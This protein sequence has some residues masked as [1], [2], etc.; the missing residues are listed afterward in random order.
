MDN[1]RAYL[2]PGTQVQLE[3]GSLYTITGAP[4]GSGGGSILYPAE[5]IILHGDTAV[6]DGIVYVLKECYPISPEH[7]F[8]RDAQGQIRPEHPEK[9]EQAYL[10]RVKQM[11]L[12][13]RQ[14]T[15]QIYRTSSRLIPIR[16]AAA[17]VFLTVPGG[18]PV[19][20]ENTV[21][22]MED[23][24]S[25]GQSLDA[26]LHQQCRMTTLQVFR[27]IQQVLFALREIHQAG[28]L[29]LDI[30]GGNIFIK[31]TLEDESDIATIID[32]GSARPLIN[33]QTEPI[34]D[35]VIFTTHGFS[36]PEIL[37]HNDGTLRLGPEADLYSVGCLLLYL[38]TGSRYSVNEL[39]SNTTGKY[40][41]R[42]KLRKLDCPRH[43]VDR[44]QGI[45]AHALA[46][47]PAQRYHTAE[48]ML[49]DVTGLLKAL[50]PYRSDLAAV[51]YD[52]FVCYRHGP[53]DSKAAIALQRHLEQ[54]RA[55][56]GISAA[57]HPFHRVFV[58]EGELSSCADFGAQI[59]AALKNAGWLI[60]IC[61]PDTPGSAWVQLEI[62]TF[63]EYH[64]RSRILAVLTGGEPAESFPP[65]LL[66]NKD[67]Q[68]VLA[69][70]ARGKD[71]GSVLAKLKK[72]ALL[73]IVAPML[74]TTYDTLKQRRR[75]YAFQRTAILAV[76]ALAFTACFAA[77]TVYQNR[78]TNEAYQSM[79]VSQ[80]RYL[81]QV[82]GQ[83]LSEGDRISAIQVALEALPKGE[84]DNSRPLVT[85]ALYALNNAVYAY[86]QPSFNDFIVKGTLDTES[87][88]SI[89]SAGLSPSGNHLLV[90][91]ES[92]RMNLFDLETD[93]QIA[94]ITP[95]DLVAHP[96]D[97]MIYH[98][99]YLADDQMIVFL[100]D[101]VLCWKLSTQT[102][103][104]SVPYE[105]DQTEWDS[106]GSPYDIQVDSEI[107]SSGSIQSILSHN[108][109][110]LFFT[111]ELKSD[112]Y[113]YTLD[114]ASGAVTARVSLDSAF[115]NTDV[116]W[117]FFS[118]PSAI[119][120]SE[121]GRYAVLGFSDMWNGHSSITAPLLVDLQ[122][123]ECFVLENRA[124]TVGSAEILSICF[125]SEQ[126]IA[127][128]S[129]DISYYSYYPE[130]HFYEA[131]CYDIRS[132]QQLWH[133]SGSCYTD[134]LSGSLQ[135]E[136]QILEGEENAE[137]V[138]VLNFGNTIS[139]LS[140]DSGEIRSSVSCAFDVAGYGKYADSRLFVALEDGTLLQLVYGS[141]L[142][143]MSSAQG[144][145]AA[146]VYRPE[147][148]EFLLFEENGTF[149]TIMSNQ[150]GDLN[151]TKMQL[152][153][154]HAY[155]GYHS[156]GERS[157][158]VI[159]SNNLLSVYEPLS[160]NPIAETEAS[161]DYQV[162]VIGIRNTDDGPVLW[163]LLNGFLNGFSITD[164]E[165]SSHIMLPETEYE[166]ARDSWQP[167]GWSQERCLLYNSLDDSVIYSVDI[168]SASA[169]KDIT[170]YRLE[171]N[172]HYTD[173]IAV[174]QDGKYLAAILSAS[175]DYT[176]VGCHLA[177]LNLETNQWISL[178]DSLA[179]LDVSCYTDSY[180]YEKYCYSDDAL[181][182]LPGG[183]QLAVLANGKIQ[184][185]DLDAQTILQSVDISCSTQCSI[186][187]LSEDILLV[188][189]DSGRLATWDLDAQNVVSTSEYN[190]F[191]H[192][193][194]VTLMQLD[195]TH[196]YAIAPYGVLSWNW[197][198]YVYEFDQKGN[199]SPYLDLL[200]CNIDLYS[201]EIFYLFSEEGTM[202]AGYYR[203]YTLDEL[204]A[205]AN[206]ILA[207]QS[208]SES[209]RTK[210]FIDSS[211]YL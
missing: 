62:D 135:L 99:L 201:G 162:D 121:D 4:I 7:S 196:F 85:E 80:S 126:Q 123:G 48:E 158:R 111:V 87:L 152:G 191:S 194:P 168:C 84:A 10:D 192:S 50:Q 182:F 44:L 210:Y 209:K 18:E 39:L 157:Y 54:F 65:Q 1:A 12:D 70:D 183:H 58:D 77:Y 177:V 33:G 98:A 23:L 155:I 181:S 200:N 30:Q 198:T 63:L 6:L 116:R 57:R 46:R 110:F 2:K 47:E 208:L 205:R 32:F 101:Q 163:Y 153:R 79:L 45:I 122:T 94:S 28:Y 102:V 127:V 118:P 8:F 125:L 17:R 21:T 169:E 92:G 73:R 179:A 78:Q 90:L 151:D 40:L 37:L 35:R 149:V 25:K 171:E 143:E 119:A 204:I 167:A 144:S 64:D 178:D 19:L 83:L 159:C 189:G 74:G 3:N 195:E 190:F 38:L 140:P 15:Q 137:P 120:I 154:D 76:I 95:S 188:L 55:S 75:T 150:L 89:A 14:V 115:E 160:A 193:F 186:L 164:N 114:T 16:E 156:D 9:G 93:Q 49:A 113:C 20:V 82:S 100:A 112:L 134:S 106:D 199:I 173:F 138:L 96:A 26:C 133:V 66:A 146:A 180:G 53:I 67:Q 42:F 43:L 184:I 72:D 161:P 105:R 202:H 109:S 129:A 117:S 185:V 124:A 91:D 206:E 176:F 61:S 131:A 141:S 175:Q 103:L 139:F 86:W 51:T 34:A 130:E 29:H 52:A 136:T 170:A 107:S 165:L 11:Q 104:W 97:S 88:F 145:F 132:G 27:I 71:V 36:A 24:T 69:A 203:L 81:A 187:C 13:E 172:L 108:G 56:K 41:T 5:R 147:Q 166:N 148:G 59:R 128:L 174:S 211:S 22:V 68:E 207:G 197:W 142:Y 31:G 60:V